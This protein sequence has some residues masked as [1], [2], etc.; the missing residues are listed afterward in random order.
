MSKTQNLGL[1]LTDSTEGS[2][3]FKDWMD[4]LTGTKSTSNMQILDGEVGGVK[5]NL[6]SHTSNMGIHVSSNDKQTW[7]GKAEIVRGY[8][9]N[10]S[11]YEEEAHS[12]QL[13]PSANA[14]YIDLGDEDGTMY[15]W[16][17][18]TSS[19]VPVSSGA[20]SDYGTWG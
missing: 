16:E 3:L 13:T 2:V 5:T 8:Y 17:A 4:D 14:F 20:D 1:E 11:F 15:T 9:Y 18:T 19:Y 7:N 6:S 10:G 12:T